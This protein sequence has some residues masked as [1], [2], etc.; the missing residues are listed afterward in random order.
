[1]G[2]KLKIEAK[3]NSN[4]EEVVLEQGMEKQRHIQR[5]LRLRES[6]TPGLENSDPK[7]LYSFENIEAM[8][9]Y[10]EMHGFEKIPK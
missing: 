6:D 2:V 10:D 8:V 1:M 5:I 9:F 3:I 7:K 4:G